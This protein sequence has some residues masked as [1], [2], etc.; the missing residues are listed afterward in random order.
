MNP[1]ALV[2]VILMFV[3]PVFSQDNIGALK[4][5]LLP[6]KVKGDTIEVII[7]V[8]NFS[9]STVGFVKPELDFVNFHIMN[10]MAFG[11]KKKDSVLYKGDNSQL[12]HITVSKKSCDLLKPGEEKEYL[13]SLDHNLFWGKRSGKRLKKISVEI[14]Y[15]NNEIV[16]RDCDIPLF[17]G[18]L[19]AENVVVYE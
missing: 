13:F 19:V 2:L 11:M 3:S 16:C 15:S 18:R 12:D 5:N 1:T 14:S 4:L 10:F 6:G 17:Y 8:K 9:D 7:Q